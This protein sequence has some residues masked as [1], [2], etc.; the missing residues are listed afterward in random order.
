MVRI[1]SRAAVELPNGSFVKKYSGTPRSDP[2]LKQMSCRLVR[3]NSTLVLT[4]V[5]SLGTVT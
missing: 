3:L 2:A 1:M 4:F 5:K